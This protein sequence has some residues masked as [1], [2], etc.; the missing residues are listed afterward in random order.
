[1]AIIGCPASAEVI[2]TYCGTTKEFSVIFKETEQTLIAYGNSILGKE[3]AT[4]IW[5]NQFTKTY[6]IINK[7][8]KTGKICVLDG[9]NNLTF[10]KE[11]SL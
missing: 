2:H 9:G 8:L 11:N 6:S 7:N 5:Y 10:K 1:M 3:Y 4:F